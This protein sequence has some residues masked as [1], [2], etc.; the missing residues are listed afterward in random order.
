MSPP[1]LGAADRFRA[2]LARYYGALE[3]PAR[4][5]AR[6]RIVIDTE[7]IW[8][9]AVYRFGQYLKDEAPGLIRVPLRIPCA[10]VRRLLRWTV[11]IHLFPDTEI[12]P[13]LYIGHYGG[14]WISPRARIGA[15]CSIAHQVTIGT[16]DPR[17]APTLGDRVWVGPGAIVTGPITVG[18]GAVVGANSLVAASVPDNAV[19]L[20]VPARIMS[21][22]GSA[23]LLTPSTAAKT[24][25]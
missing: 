16:A 22:S 18:S 8:A 23:T 21:Y 13:G 24:P 17:G 11:G 12:G 5:R 2:D 7:A 19:V 9:I 20:G 10:I 4:R 3:A 14:I 15:H 25:D 6:L 1:A